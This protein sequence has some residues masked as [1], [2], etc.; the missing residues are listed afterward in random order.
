MNHSTLVKVF[1][2][3]MVTTV[4]LMIV[5]AAIA[6]P[7]VPVVAGIMIA[8]VWFLARSNRR[9]RR[10]VTHRHVQA[11]TDNLRRDYDVSVYNDGGV[12]NVYG[13]AGRGR[14]YYAPPIGEHDGVIRRETV[15]GEEY[16]IRVWGH[17]Q[18]LRYDHEYDITHGQAGDMWEEYRRIGETRQDAKARVLRGRYGIPIPEP[19]RNCA[20]CGVNIIHH[21]SLPHAFEEIE[22]IG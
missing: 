3:W 8:P 5:T 19:D 14:S 15:D 18:R 16:E 7:F 9:H 1:A 6:L 4:L 11:L 13:D 10:N 22:E 21:V 17:P 20:R 2:A 12:V